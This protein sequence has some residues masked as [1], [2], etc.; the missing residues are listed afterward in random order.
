MCRDLAQLTGAV[1][2]DL[3]PRGPFPLCEDRKLPRRE[4][5]VSMEDTVDQRSLVRL[6]FGLNYRGRVFQ[7]VTPF[8][9]ALVISLM[10]D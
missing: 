7:K 5:A 8:A 10:T 1:I 9:S 2:E 4:A 6:Q 3:R